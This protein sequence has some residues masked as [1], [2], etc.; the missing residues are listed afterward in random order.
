MAATTINVQAVQDNISQSIK[1]IET[2][3]KALAN[4]SSTINSMNGIWE[5]EDQR[6]Y[7]EQFQGTKNKIENFNQGVL[8]SLNAMKQYVNDCVSIDSQTGSNLRNIGW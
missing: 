1:H 4:I 5:A 3:E 6:V 2:Q 7:S 8:E